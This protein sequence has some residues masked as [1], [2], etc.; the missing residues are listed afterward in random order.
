M[1]LNDAWYRFKVNYN[2]KLYLT[3]EP[4]KE[5]GTSR[6]LSISLT[7][8]NPYKK[9]EDIDYSLTYN[10]DT[11]VSV[12]TYADITGSVATGC[13]QVLK[14][15]GDGN[16]EVYYSCVQ[17]TSGTL[18]HQ[19]E[20]DGTYIIR[21]IFKLTSE[22]DSVEQVVDEI[23]RQGTSAR[24][25]I[26]DKFGQVIS[27]ILIGTAA[28]LGIAIGSIPLGLG[29]IGT[30]VVLVNLMGWLNIS[31][32]VLYGLISIIILIAINLRRRR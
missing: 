1:R 25:I 20:D 14:T 27:L 12:F 32:S 21:A 8:A 16:T 5:S 28:V 2:D 24:F 17:S 11:N 15:E 30:T 22:F 31:G 9:F 7:A 3:T 26:I 4:R 10:E 13:L 23:V 29:L 18:S 6:I 19:I